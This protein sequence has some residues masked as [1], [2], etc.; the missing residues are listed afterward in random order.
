MLMKVSWWERR[1]L[2][3]ETI[4]ERAWCTVPRTAEFADVFVQTYTAAQL[5]RR[6]AA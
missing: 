6:S 1:R 2:S 4:L 5:G 3:P